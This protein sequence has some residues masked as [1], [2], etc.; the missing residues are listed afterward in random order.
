ML[1]NCQQSDIFTSWVGEV[2]L[3]VTHSST[4]IGV[5]FLYSQLYRNRLYKFYTNVCSLQPGVKQIIYDQHAER[6][7]NWRF[8]S[9]II[10]KRSSHHQKLS[11]VSFLDTI[12]CISV[13]C[14]KIKIL[15]INHA[16]FSHI[17]AT[18]KWNSAVC[19]SSQKYSD[20]LYVLCAA[21]FHWLCHTRCSSNLTAPSLRLYWHV[22]INLTIIRL[23]VVYKLLHMG[24]I[25]CQIIKR[26]LDGP[27]GRGVHDVNRKQGND[28]ASNA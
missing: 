14:L 23:A 15:K 6:Y 5:S 19:K 18:A 25:A 9:H 8:E 16:A 13:A 22:G 26:I 7:N 1:P 28:P 10:T 27:C 24:L 3:H 12:R 4:P 20:E 21:R 2:W 17:S 11:V